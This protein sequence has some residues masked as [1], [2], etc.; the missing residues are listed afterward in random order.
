[1]LE[2]EYRGLNI[3][4]EIS[5]V[6]VAID[7]IQK[8]IHIYDTNQVVEP[9]YNFS[10]K[11][12]QT[13]EGFYKM[14]KVLYEKRFLELRSQTIAEWVSEITWFFYGSKNSILKYQ[15]DDFVEISK[16]G[17]LQE[18]HQGIQPLYQKYLLRVI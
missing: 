6:E 13:S 2:L 9:E 17:N 1:M 18:N 14:T 11:K 3:L 16:K 4:D 7:A 8:V 5:T 10:K 15:K 12:Y